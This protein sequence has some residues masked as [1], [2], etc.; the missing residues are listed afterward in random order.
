MYTHISL[1]LSLYMYIYIYIYIYLSIYIHIYRERCIYIYRERERFPT[2][3]LHYS[4][5][6]LDCTN[7]MLIILRINI[8]LMYVLF[9]VLY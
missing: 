2:N 7:L 8:L 9:N 4:V 6:V 5:I 3:A 1:S